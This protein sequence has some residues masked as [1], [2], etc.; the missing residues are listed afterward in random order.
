M[1]RRALNPSPSAVSHLSILALN[2]L[3]FLWHVCPQQLSESLNA[4]VAFVINPSFQP[5]AMGLPMGSARNTLTGT[6]NTQREHFASRR[7]QHGLT[8]QC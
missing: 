6:K 4:R 1:R 7:F 2:R 5:L 8:A 3:W